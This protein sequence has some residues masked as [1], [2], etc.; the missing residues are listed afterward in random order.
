MDN[1]GIKSASGK[2]SS[3]LKTLYRHLQGSLP[4]SVTKFKVLWKELTLLPMP[5]WGLSL[6]I[7]IGLGLLFQSRPGPQ[8]EPTP[9]PKVVLPPRLTARSVTTP[10][11]YTPLANSEA[12]AIFSMTPVPSA[13]ATPTPRPPLFTF[14][15]IKRGETLISIA[16]VYGGQ[17]NQ[18]P[19]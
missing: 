8:A 7:L 18:G 16:S 13:T 3:Y 15:K 19:D 5:L 11:V 12:P 9:L 14:H 6:A 17:P 4:T 1:F 10:V 2:V